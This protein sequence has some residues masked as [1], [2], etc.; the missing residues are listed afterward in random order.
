MNMT[1]NQP[2]ECMNLI[3][4]GRRFFYELSFKKFI[5]YSMLVEFSKLQLSQ[6]NINAP[7]DSVSRAKY[8]TLSWC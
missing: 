5:Y 3:T 4:A 7:L 2:E 6:L 8:R 1:A